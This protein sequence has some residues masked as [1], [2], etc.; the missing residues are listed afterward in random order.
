MPGNCEGTIQLDA[1][2]FSKVIG[3]S[4]FFLPIVYVCVVKPIFSICRFNFVIC[5]DQRIAEN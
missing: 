4:Y 2:V 1:A 3:D 5:V